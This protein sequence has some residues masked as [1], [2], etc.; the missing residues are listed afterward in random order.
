[1][2]YFVADYI[3]LAAGRVVVVVAAADYPVA[4]VADNPADNPAAVYNLHHR[5]WDH[6][7]L[8]VPKGQE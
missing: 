2:T 8:N 1:M 6:Y 5:S 3:A 7:H 4:V